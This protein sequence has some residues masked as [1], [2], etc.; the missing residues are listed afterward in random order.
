MNK[1]KEGYTYW[2]EEVSPRVRLYNYTQIM[3]RGIH[4]TDTQEVVMKYG[5]KSEIAYQMRKALEVF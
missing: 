1:H 5:L 3:H 2:T 4:V